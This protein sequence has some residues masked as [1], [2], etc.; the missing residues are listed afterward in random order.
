MIWQI[1]GMHYLWR[2]WSNSDPRYR[3]DLSLLLKNPCFLIMLKCCSEVYFFACWLLTFCYTHLNEKQ[4]NHKLWAKFHLRGS[5]DTNLESKVWL[6][7]FLLKFL[8]HCYQHEICSYQI[9]LIK[10]K[11]WI[12]NLFNSLYNPMISILEPDLKYTPIP[13]FAAALSLSIAKTLIS[14]FILNIYQTY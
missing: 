14:S 11:I 1:W 2:P 8:N 12:Q 9:H 6:I 4:S 7:C 13:I 10:L 3:I 5:G